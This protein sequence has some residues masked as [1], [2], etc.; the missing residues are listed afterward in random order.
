MGFGYWSFADCTG[1]FGEMATS[2]GQIDH[3]VGADLVGLSLPIPL[4]I[5]PIIGCDLFPVF[6]APFGITSPTALAL[7]FCTW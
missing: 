6:S 3:T 5:S 2:N 7:R 1:L 4:T